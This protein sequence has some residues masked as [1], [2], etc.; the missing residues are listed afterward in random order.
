MVNLEPSLWV[1]TLQG[2]ACPYTKDAS[3][4]LWGCR[5]DPVRTRSGPHEVQDPYIALRAAHCL[6]TNNN[7]EYDACGKCVCG[8]ALGC[9]MLEVLMD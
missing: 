7:N 6:P 4:T 3:G 9:R 5:T 8:H 2:P 1:R